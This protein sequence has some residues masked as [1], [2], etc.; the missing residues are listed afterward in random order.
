MKSLCSGSPFYIAPEVLQGKVS[1]ACDMWSVGVVMY[2][3]L[4]GKL[5]FPG[6]ST[7]EI[8]NNVMFKELNL[9]DDPD[10]E[11]VSN[12]AKELLSMMF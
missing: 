12:E 1:L 11:D 7:E 2:L 4:S 3:C 8:F 6:E 9:F 10:L 5:P